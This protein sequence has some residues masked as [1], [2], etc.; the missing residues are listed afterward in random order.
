MSGRLDSAVIVVVGVKPVKC[1]LRPE[2]VSPFDRDRGKPRVLSCCKRE[3]SKNRALE[4]SS[5]F[6]EE[7]IWLSSSFHLANIVYPRTA[8]CSDMCA[9]HTTRCPRHASPNRH[10]NT[11]RN[12]RLTVACS[13]L[14]IVSSADFIRPLGSHYT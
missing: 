2:G 6:V 13:R 7:A 4:I 5:I 9:S 3:A 12:V 14:S 11:Q 10:R 1:E 8:A